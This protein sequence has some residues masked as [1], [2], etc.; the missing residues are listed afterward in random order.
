MDAPEDRS[1]RRV[2]AVGAVLLGVLVPLVLA[3]PASGSETPARTAG[4]ATIVIHG[5]GR[6]TSE[7]PGAIDCP[8]RCT[9]AFTGSTQLTPRRGGNRV[10]DRAARVLR[11]RRCTVALNDFTYNLDVYFRP[12]AELQLW[13]RG[14]GAI[15]VSPQPADDRGLPTAP[16]CNRENAFEGTGCRFY[17]LPGTRVTAAAS[18]DPGSTFLGWSSR[19]CPGTGSCTVT[20]S[21]DD[22]SLVAR[23]TPLEVRVIKEGLGPERSSA[24]RRGSRARRRARRRSRPGRGSRSSRGPIR[25][26]RSSAGS[27]AAPSPGRIR[28]AACSWRRTGPTGSASRSARTTRSAPTN[29]SVLSD[30]VREG[31]GGVVGRQLDCGGTCGAST[32]SAPRRSCAPARPAAGASRPGA[33]RARSSR[34]AG[35]TSG[36]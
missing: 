21:R 5:Q 31:Q 33:A 9:L 18:A 17:Y 28:T 7:P 34:P 29:L 24:S 12:R 27:S 30:V 20:M 6:V 22:V 19:D 14:D 3:L 36:P 23:Y 25:R 32:G 11:Q 16:T 13:P 10:G 15:T 26:R 8:G 1:L 35:S 2:R 4:S